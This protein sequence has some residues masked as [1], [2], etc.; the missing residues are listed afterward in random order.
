MTEVAAPKDLNITTNPG[1]DL[2]ENLGAAPKARIITINPDLK[3]V[4]E[5]QNKYKNPKL[6][7]SDYFIDKCFI[8]SPLFFGSL[9]KERSKYKLQYMKTNTES[10]VTIE[11]NPFIKAFSNAYNNHQDV[12]VSPDDIWLLINNQFSELVNA[13]SEKLKSLFTNN[14]STNPNPSSK[15][16]LTV[17]TGP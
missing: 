6:L 10:P 9:E 3:E 13:N 7:T 14:T 11:H 5:N 2:K 1:L 15:I 16:N 8:D 17:N 12:V 4:I